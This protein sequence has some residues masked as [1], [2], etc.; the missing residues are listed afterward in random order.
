MPGNE[1]VFFMMSPVFG[2]ISV[3]LKFYNLQV[4]G[5]QSAN[6]IHQVE[7]MGMIENPYLNQT[8][9]KSACQIFLPNRIPESKIWN[10]KNP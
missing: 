8:T 10:P 4:W 1:V 2:Y 3:S 7:V 9:Q 6:V 5:L